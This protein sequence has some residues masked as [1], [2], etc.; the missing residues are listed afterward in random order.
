M[1]DT[2]HMRLSGHSR[3]FPLT[4]DAH[5]ELLRYLSQARSALTRE[6]DGDETLRDIEASIGE[7][8]A[9]LR[10]DS[11]GPITDSQMQAVLTQAGTIST[12]KSGPDPDTSSRG[13]FW[14]R[15]TEGRW[16]GG[17]C[18]GV[19]ARGSFNPA[20]VRGIAGVAV[21]LL[22]GILGPLGQGIPMLLFLAAVA[23]G[24]L[25]LMLVLPPVASVAEYRRLS[26]APRAPGS[27]A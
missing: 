7:Q 4:E 11:T 18:L 5:S 27:T 1:T 17:I 20:W 22:A 6:P 23:L 12:E 24:Y 9:A 14:A 3:V 19:A 16:L 15:I 25:V 10:D 2:R 21:F 13:L 8:L 26:T